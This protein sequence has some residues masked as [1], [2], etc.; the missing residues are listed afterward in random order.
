M[1]L[2]RS[3][4]NTGEHAVGGENAPAQVLFL[5]VPPERTPFS[6]YS[7]WATRSTSQARASRV[8]KAA[9]FFFGALLTRDSRDEQWWVEASTVL[10]AKA[11]QSAML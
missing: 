5:S 3:T 10:S 4:T 9:L 8:R 6:P 2:G 7:S 11:T 1:N